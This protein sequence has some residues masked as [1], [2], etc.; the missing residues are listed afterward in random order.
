VLEVRLVDIADANFVEPVVVPCGK[1]D[2]VGV[3]DASFESAAQYRLEVDRLVERRLVPTGAVLPAARRRRRGLQIGGGLADV[4]D[5]RALVD[6]PLAKGFDRPVEGRLEPGVVE[7][8]AEELVVGGVS[9]IR[10]RRALISDTRLE[11]AVFVLQIV[12]QRLVVDGRP[13]RYRLSSV[14]AGSLKIAKR[15][16]QRRPPRPGSRRPRPARR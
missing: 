14:G 10:E 11:F 13:G 6:L 1:G 5:G 2:A 4:D 8:R 3:V 9:P 16:I 15:V 7:G 12:D